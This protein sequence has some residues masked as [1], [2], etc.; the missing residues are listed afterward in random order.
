MLITRSKLLVLAAIAV[1]LLWIE[2]SRG[3]R[4]EA[5]TPAEVSAQAAGCPANESTPFSPECMAFIQGALE[6]PDR[7]R[8]N[9][10]DALSVESHD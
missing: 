8:L 9:H 2:H 3:I 5:P 6:P 4:I 7:R 1:A 10:P